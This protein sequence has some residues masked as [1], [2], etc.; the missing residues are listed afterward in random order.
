VTALLAVRS[1]GRLLPRG[2]SLPDAVW[3]RRHRAI[4]VIALAQA[5]GLGVLTAVWGHGLLAAVYVAVLV[6]TPLVPAAAPWFGRKLRAAAATTGLMA[7]SVALVQLWDGTTEAHFHFFVMVGV[8]SLYQDWLPFGVGLLI[9]VLH[10]GVMG[11]IAPHHVFGTHAAQQDPWLWA[12]IHGVF[13]LGASV[14]HL[15]SWRLNEEQVLQDQLT[16]LA[17]RT[18]LEEQLRRLLAGREQVTLLLLDLD[19]FKDVNDVRGHTSG[20]AVLREVAQ[21][22]R[23][24]VRAGDLVARPGGDEFAVLAAGSPSGVASLGDRL[25]AAVRAPLALPD[26]SVVTLSASLGVATPGDDEE[27]TAV[28]LMRNADLAMYLAK[29][30]GGD[31]VA[32]YA[33]G[34]AERARDRS[35]LQRDLAGATAAGQLRVHYQ[36]VV[37]AADG[38]PVGY[39]ALV[40]WEHPGRGLVPPAEFI[41]LA[42]ETGAVTEIGRWVLRAAV[43]QCAA[44]SVASARPLRMSVNLSPRQM[45]D[46][47]VPALVAEVLADSGLPARQLTLEVTE[48]VFVHDVDRVVG[49]LHRLR[50]LGVR[51]AIDDFGTG[52][53]SLS[54]LR[55]LPA[56]VLKIDRSFVADLPGSRSSAGLVA[57]IIELARTLHLDVV[58]EGVETDAQ[59]RCLVDLGCGLAQG[60]LFARPG[61]AEDCTPAALEPAALGAALAG[62]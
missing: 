28:A 46:E 12:G 62:R 39:E 22:L 1:V 44:W 26:G 61:P 30:R 6:A 14:A 58:A 10:H 34:M 38:T 43:A 25:L 47:D 3:R 52:F 36:P 42:E 51:I 23:G 20:D 32:V 48:G 2:R 50:A 5:V 60:Y 45:L 49:Q 35:Q 27:R 18:M 29:S 56:D 40:R 16:G 11:T 9:V 8:V 57:S 24:C 13:V 33:E 7:A 53:S 55:R 17:N 15:T 4:V 41:P 59:R 21:R 31:G 54:Y 19:D 37:H